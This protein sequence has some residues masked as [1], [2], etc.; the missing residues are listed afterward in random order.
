MEGSTA[1]FSEWQWRRP[2]G[3]VSAIDWRGHEKGEEIESLVSLIST[4]LTR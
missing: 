1:Q 3:Q 4:E 2:S